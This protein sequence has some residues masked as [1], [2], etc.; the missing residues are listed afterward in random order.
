[1]K[2]V[3]ILLSGLILSGCYPSEETTAKKPWLLSYYNTKHQKWSWDIWGAYETKEWCEHNG[4]KNNAEGNYHCAFHSNDLFLAAYHYLT[5]P[6]QG[7]YECL[8]KSIK[9]SH[10]K[11]K[12]QYGPFLKGKGTPV[13]KAPGECVW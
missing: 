5:N 10:I 1:M 7:Q 12:F 8:F 9:P 13:S 4:K 2:I 3:L 6:N 11:S